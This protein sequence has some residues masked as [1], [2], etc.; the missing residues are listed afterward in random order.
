MKVLLRAFGV[1]E[2]EYDAPIQREGQDLYFVHRNKDHLYSMMSKV[3]ELDKIPDSVMKKA[4]FKW[5]GKWE[6]E[7]PVYEFTNL[8]N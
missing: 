3:P 2:R 6:E 8:D 5:F 1:L 7:S 4:V